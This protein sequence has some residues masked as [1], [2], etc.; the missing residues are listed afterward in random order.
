MS[1]SRIYIKLRSS[2]SKWFRIHPLTLE[3]IVLLICN[4][5]KSK[6]SLFI[7]KKTKQ[8]IKLLPNSPIKKGMFLDGIIRS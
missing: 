6:L 1:S 8:N 4:N 3:H 7:F 5:N 2:V